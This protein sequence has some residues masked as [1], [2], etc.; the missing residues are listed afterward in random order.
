LRNKAAKPTTITAGAGATTSASTGAALPVRLA[1]TVTDTNGNAVPGVR[2][3]FSAPVRGPS[4]RF[5]SHHARTVS[6]DTDAD[7]VAVAPTFYANA[8]SGGYVVRARARGIH[9]PAAFALVNRRAL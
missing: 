2:V 6:V 8:E 1:V 7:G 9:R 5:G 4:G 3:T